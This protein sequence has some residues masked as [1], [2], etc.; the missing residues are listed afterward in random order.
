MDGGTPPD[1]SYTFKHAL[2]RDAAVNSLLRSEFRRVNA[3]ITALLE[4]AEPPPRSELIA[5]H[6]ELGG[7]DGSDRYVHSSDDATA[8]G[9]LKM[10]HP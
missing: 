5:H 4:A 8:G 2:V 10:P 1:A 7:L 6:A 3:N 9:L